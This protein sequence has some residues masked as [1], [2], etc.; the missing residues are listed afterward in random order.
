MGGYAAASMMNRAMD[1]KKKMQIAEA[2]KAST[3]GTKSAPDKGEES[4]GLVFLGNV[5]KGTSQ[6]LILAECSKYGTVSSIG[7]DADNFD[8]LEGAQAL[9]KFTSQADAAA[10]VQK[11]SRRVGLFGASETHL[12]EIRLGKPEDVATPVNRRGSDDD[13][14]PRAQDFLHAARE[15][16]HLQGQMGKDPP[17]DQ[18]RRQGRHGDRVDDVVDRERIREPRGRQRLP[19]RSRSRER[20][21]GEPARIAARE[22]RPR[23]R[24]Q[25]EVAQGGRER[26]QFR[27]DEQPAIA[28]RK[29]KEPP[30]RAPRGAY[31][32]EYSDYSE[33]DPLLSR[34]TG[35]ERKVVPSRV[36]PVEPSERKV[37]GLGGFDTNKKAAAEPAPMRMTQQADGSMAVADAPSGGVQVGTKGHWAEFATEGNR[38]Y[39]VH[40]LTGERTWTKPLEYDSVASQPLGGKQQER[41]HSNLYIGNLPRGCTES[42]YR[43]LLQPFGTIVAFKL[44][45]GKVP[46]GPCYGFVKYSTIIEAQ[47]CI[48]AVNG[49]VWNGTTLNARLSHMDLKIR[50]EQLSGVNV[51]AT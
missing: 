42:L 46:S 44:V 2:E 14:T 30:G 11:M 43:Q 50:P 8:L 26:R 36:V 31:A 16:L 47:M 10:A 33:D 12:I 6:G 40:I 25:E 51:Q 23:G 17:R 21:R 37:R 32:S 4:P 18:A 7:Y 22:E 34:E 29:R 13:D 45:P 20:R 48:N 3:T 41:G 38:P 5:P 19:E 24:R 1:A 15:V 35:F 39:F 9:V 28:R 49:A 27:E